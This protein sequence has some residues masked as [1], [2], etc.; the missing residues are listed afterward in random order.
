MN[1]GVKK[2]ENSDIFVEF[3]R[4]SSNILSYQNEE[5]RF[6]SIVFKNLHYSSTDPVTLPGKGQFNLNILKEISG[7]DSYL[8]LDQDVRGCQN[9]EPY[10]NCT[11]RQYIQ[12]I[13]DTC[14]CLP[15]PVKISEN[16]V[17]RI[18]IF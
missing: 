8:G 1:R 16:E 15:F 18:M 11:T 7:T 12:A 4:I 3:L 2:F 17:H 6:Y 14:G 9:D 5:L 13:R 10:D